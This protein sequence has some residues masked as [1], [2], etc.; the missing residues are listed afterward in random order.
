MP[1]VS[2]LVCYFY[3]SRHN[4]YHCTWH[5]RIDR[6][7]RLPRLQPR[8][9][10]QGHSPERIPLRMTASSFWRSAA[11]VDRHHA[12]DAVGELGDDDL[13]C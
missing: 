9:T 1:P 2:Q 4:V 8:I 10:G 7:W 5:E 13:R 12:L 3:L 11:V 6:H